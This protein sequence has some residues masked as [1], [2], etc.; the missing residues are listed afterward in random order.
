MVVK[1]WG[2]ICLC[3]FL[4]CTNSTIQMDNSDVSL[5]HQNLMKYAQKVSVFEENNS[6]IIQVK[7]NTGQL[8]ATYTFPQKIH[9]KPS[10]VALSSVFVGFLT[11]IKQDE[12]I[13]AVDDIRFIHHPNIVK[14]HELQRIVSIGSEGGLNYEK[15]LELN[16]DYVIY[17][18]SSDAQSGVVDRMEKAGMKFVICNNYLENSPLGR[19][20]WI[21]VF[22]IICGRY[23]EANALFNLIETNYIT[24][25]NKITDQKFIKPKVLVGSMY[26]GVWDVPARNSYTAQ[27]LLDAGTDLIWSDHSPINRFPLSLEQVVSIALNA[28]FWINVGQFTSLSDLVNAD[29]RYRY[30]E[31]FKSQKVY[32]NNKQVNAFGGNAFWETGPVRPDWVLNDLF[33]IFHGK[34]EL[35]DSL[36]YYRQLN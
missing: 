14:Q 8:I 29:N 6:F 25:K 28:P 34:N 10:I 23:D 4:A 33:L 1:I 9:Q 26:A 19:A 31:A 30:F 35:Y 17:T 13:V 21:K 36:R 7:N 2:F 5:E 12:C 11:A 32:N 3:L 18:G 22:G 27:L 24:L 20:E 15:L 16:P